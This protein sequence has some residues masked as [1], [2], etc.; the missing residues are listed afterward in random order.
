MKE[1]TAVS[2]FLRNLG[3]KFLLVGLKCLRMGSQGVGQRGHKSSSGQKKVTKETTQQLPSWAGSQQHRSLNPLDLGLQLLEALLQNTHY[4]P[5]PSQPHHP[6]CQG[7]GRHKLLKG[8]SQTTASKT[9]SRETFMGET[10]HNV[11]LR[12]S[13]DA[14]YNSDCH[15]KSHTKHQ[16]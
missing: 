12:V 6:L 8:T 1:N 14:I 16:Q 5:S 15:R 2:V 4:P 3:T 9:A 11:H 13:F 10:D 7:Y